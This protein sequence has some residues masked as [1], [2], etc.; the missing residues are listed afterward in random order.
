MPP[1][2]VRTSSVGDDAGVLTS[3]VAL[4]VAAY[5]WWVTGLRPFS[6]GAT[7]AVV[8]AGAAAVLAGR[9]RLPPRPAGDGTARD[10]APWAALVAALVAWQLAAWA[11]EPR[12]DHPTLSSLT[13]AALDARPLRAA[14]VVAWLAAAAWLGRR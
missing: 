5:A 3:V 13:N 11:Q 9:L 14:A 8:G 6:A 7:I 4:A 2:T 10:A 1:G 12:D